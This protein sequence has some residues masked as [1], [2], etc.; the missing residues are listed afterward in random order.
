MFTNVS[1]YGT[2]GRRRVDRWVD[3]LAGAALLEGGHTNWQ[4]LQR[5]N[6]PAAK[7]HR[8]AVGFLHSFQPAEQLLEASSVHEC[9]LHLD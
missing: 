7:G 5:R 9:A 6:H 1:K 8:P 3:S 2:K 4:R